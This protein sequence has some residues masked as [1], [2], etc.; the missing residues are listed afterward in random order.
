MRVKTMKR[1]LSAAII[2]AT[3]VGYCTQSQGQM[4]YCP[5]APQAT[6]PYYSDVPSMSGDQ[7]P[8][9]QPM[10]SLPGT[11]SGSNR[12]SNSGAMD[13]NSSFDNSTTPPPSSE[14]SSGATGG[15]AAAYAGGGGGGELDTPNM[16]GD[17]FFSTIVSGGPGSGSFS[18][19][20]P[21]QG[22]AA[23]DRRFKVSDGISPIPTDRVFYNYRHFEN[24]INTGKQDINVDRNLFGLEKTF[25]DRNASLELRLPFASGINSTADLSRASSGNEGTGFGNITLTS[26]FLLAHQD[27]NALTCGL[28]MTFPT[29]SDFTEL[30]TGLTADNTSY[31]LVP[32]LGML[33]QLGP[34]FFSQS[35][36]GFD[37]DLNGTKI[38]DGTVVQDQNLMYADIQGGAWLLKNRC[39]AIRSWAALLELH[40]TTTTTNADAALGSP[41]GDNIDLLN[42]TSGMS[43]GLGSNLTFNAYGAVPLRR[44]LAA[45]PVAGGPVQYGSPTFD[46]EF[47]VQLIYRPGPGGCGACLR[48]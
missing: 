32:Y 31:H 22:V 10:E 38:S 9:V 21:S 46:S 16:I 34:N 4:P 25:L 44:E 5:P 40:Y 33:K 17:L 29:G 7:N 20:S 12:D 41:F 14:F 48:R 2:A 3:S 42:L 8:T 11:G 6:T 39:G 35:Y 23:G 18:E 26:K 36:L 28:A 37:F 15:G 30:S 1:K 43:W 47:G 13:S 24:V 45:I 27:G 19:G